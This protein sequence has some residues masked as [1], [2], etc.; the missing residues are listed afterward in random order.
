MTAV[1]VVQ[2]E[3]AGLAGGEVWPCDLGFELSRGFRALKVWLSV[4]VLGVAWFR[5]LVERSCRL[6]EY[7]QALLERSS[8]FEILCPRQ[9]SIVCFRF[10]PASQRERF[11]P[12]RT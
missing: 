7:A 11:D 12:K 5:G 6:A 10:R 4:K 8:D 3:H 9:L 2:H 1:A